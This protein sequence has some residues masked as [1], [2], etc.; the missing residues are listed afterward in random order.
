MILRLACFKHNYFILFNSV[1]GHIFSITTTA[2]YFNELEIKAQTI[3]FAVFGAPS[4]CTFP[5]RYRGTSYSTCTYANYHMPWCAWD[6]NYRIGR[7]SICSKERVPLYYL[8]F[9][10][11]DKML[12]VLTIKF[13]GRYCDVLSI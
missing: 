8:N 12:F 11:T 3:S 9:I 13:S 7:W 6:S 5:F 2:F 1:P 4:Q 10:T